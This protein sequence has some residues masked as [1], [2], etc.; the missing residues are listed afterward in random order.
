[1]NFLTFA[2][3][4]WCDLTYYMKMLFYL[5]ILNV[6]VSL[7]FF[8]YKTWKVVSST[9]H[10]VEMQTKQRLF[11]WSGARSSPLPTPIV[12]VFVFF[13]LQFDGI[14]VNSYNCPTNQTHNFTPTYSVPELEA[15]YVCL[16][17]SSPCVIQVHPRCRVVALNGSL[18]LV[19]SPCFSLDVSKEI[20]SRVIVTQCDNQRRSSQRREGMGAGKGRNGPL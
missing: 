14:Q 17:T 10:D 13:A 16:L 1:M 11:T 18:S 8:T 6:F 2:C 20:L 3:I 19:Q 15:L 4:K 9:I 12:V 7:F 5:R